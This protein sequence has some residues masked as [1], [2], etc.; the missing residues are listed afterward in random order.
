[1]DIDFFEIL[2]F[3]ASGV[4]I[5]G[6]LCIGVGCILRVKLWQQ[7]DYAKRAFLRAVEDCDKQEHAGPNGDDRIRDVKDQTQR[8]DAS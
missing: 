6:L 1:M 4:A 3:V 5:V 7:D 8:G 2:C